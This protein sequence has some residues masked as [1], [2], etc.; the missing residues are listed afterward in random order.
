MIHAR[1]L[2]RHYGEPSNRV[3]ALDEIDLKIESGARVGILGRSGS[4][5]TTLLNLLAGLDR[6][7]SGSLSVVDHE[8]GDL[9]SV[10][11]AEYRRETVGV[12][13]QSF[14]LIP[15]RSAFQNVELPLILA[16]VERAERKQRVAEAIDRVGLTRRTRHKPSQLS[17]GEQQRVAV[18]RAMV[19]R[20]KVLL[21]DEPTGNLDS[22]TAESVT[23]LMLDVVAEKEST[24]ILITHDQ[25]LAETCCDRIVQLLD[26]RVLEQQNLSAEGSA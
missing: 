13:F 20:P 23:Q 16:G 19:M 25:Q 21:A 7:S 11:L 10:E 5:K 22:Q 15:N 18:A 1:Q 8:L 26:G 14:Q 4:G 6:P 9:N 24:L 3:T 12:I 2:S 17:G